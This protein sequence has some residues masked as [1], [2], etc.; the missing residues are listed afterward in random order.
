MND[1]EERGGRKRRIPLF[2]YHVCYAM[3]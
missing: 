3:V 1:E 2:F